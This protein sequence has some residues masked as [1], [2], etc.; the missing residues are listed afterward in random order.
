[1]PFGLIHKLVPHVDV[2]LENIIIRDYV[3]FQKGKRIKLAMRLSEKGY[4]ITFNILP[5][6]SRGEIRHPYT[7][8]MVRLWLGKTFIKFVTTESW[9]N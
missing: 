4:N 1:M 2:N 5:Q 3:M 6:L 9:L 7:F 8:F